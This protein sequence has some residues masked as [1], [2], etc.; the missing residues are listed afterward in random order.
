MNCPVCGKTTKQHKTSEMM[1]CVTQI[2]NDK[3]FDNIAKSEKERD[4]FQSIFDNT[5]SSGECGKG[6]MNHT[7]GEYAS[8]G[9]VMSQARAR[10][11][12]K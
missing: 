6:I 5:C 11:L 10:R 1:K 12:F 8:H 2:R 7:L 4:Q 3:K 9:N